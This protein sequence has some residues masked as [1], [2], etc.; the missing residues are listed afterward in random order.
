MIWKGDSVFK[1][2]NIYDFYYPDQIIFVMYRTVTLH[3]IYH[4]DVESHSQYRIEE[5]LFIL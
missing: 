3:K 2:V 5:R 4:T 1:Y